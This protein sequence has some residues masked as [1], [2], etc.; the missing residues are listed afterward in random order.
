[1]FIILYF[2]LILPLVYNLKSGSILDYGH[3]DEV[4]QIGFRNIENF[5][6]LK[7]GSKIKIIPIKPN[8][9]KI[10]A[11]NIN[12]QKS[13][14]NYNLE[15]TN[16]LKHFINIRRRNKQNKFFETNAIFESVYKTTSPK[17][18]TNAMTSINR[19]C[20]DG[21]KI[22]HVDDLTECNNNCQDQ[23]KYYTFDYME[24]IKN[25]KDLYEQHPRN[26]K[27]KHTKIYFDDVQY[28]FMRLY[29]KFYNCSN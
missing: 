3:Q 18:R 19:L 12:D 10:K 29:E 25:L 13:N 8:M 23:Y 21:C 9:H 26:S 28:A 14:L 22:E 27:K 5:K 16:T 6:E 1:M 2:L 15:P 4:N 7:K 20:K 24:Y 11:L 17:N